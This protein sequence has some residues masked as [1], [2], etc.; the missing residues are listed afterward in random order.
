M[1]RILVSND[2]GVNAPGIRA[3]AEALAE[4]ATVM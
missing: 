2:D 1:I 3:L 4:I